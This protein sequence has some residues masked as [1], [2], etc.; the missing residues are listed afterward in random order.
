MS[1][2]TL[3]L[4]FYSQRFEQSTRADLILLEDVLKILL[5]DFS[6][7]KYLSLT[8]DEQY[9]IY[10]LLKHFL[11]NKENIELTETEL[12][13]VKILLGDYTS[14]GPLDVVEFMVVCD[15]LLNSNLSKAIFGLRIE[16]QRKLSNILKLFLQNGEESLTPE[17]ISVF[18]ILVGKEA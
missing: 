3:D 12:E 6:G 2:G 14:E 7:D 16:M 18:E 9:K 5:Q 13:V 10:Y 1:Q 11:S 4:A 15:R 17:Q 8:V